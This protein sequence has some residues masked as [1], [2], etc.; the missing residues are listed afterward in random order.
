M[1]SRSFEK[2]LHLNIR[3]SRTLTVLL[4]GLHLLAFASVMISIPVEQ[5]LFWFLVALVCLSAAYYFQKYILLQ[6]PKS[7]VSVTQT[8][9]KDWSV[10][11]FQGDRLDAQLLGNSFKHPLLVVLNFRTCLG[12]VSVPL[13][14]DALDNDL[15]RQCRCRLTLS[16]AVEKETLF[17]R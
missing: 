3:R 12:K 13:F 16:Q 6:H 17:R 9:Q 2:V 14:P 4:L 7:V 10:Q 15:H 5:P 8:T 1:S 11:L